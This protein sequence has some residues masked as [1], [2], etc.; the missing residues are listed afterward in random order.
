MTAR[1]DELLLRRRPADAATLGVVYV[2]VLA[3]VPAG[4]VFSGLPM[5]IT[6]ATVIGLGLAVCWL[7][8]QMTSTL[9]MAKGSN[10]VR[11]AVF[12][13]AASLVASYAFA[14]LTY[15]PKDEIKL[16][17]QRVVLTVALVG[18]T[19]VICDGIRSRERLDLLMQLVV[20]ACAA[21]ALVGIFQFVLDLDLTKYL[22]P[23]GL[24]MIS[25][26]AAISQRSDFRRVAGTTAHPI[27]FGVLC[28]MALPLALHYGFRAR[29]RQENSIWWWLCTLLI[30]VGLMFSISRSAVLGLLC[31]G[32]IL[33]C[34]WSNRR[35]LRA[36]AVVVVFLAL[37]RIAFPGLLGTITGLFTNFSS[38]TS[39][40]YRTHDYP[41]AAAQIA[42]SPVFG[43]GFG[44]FYTPKYLVFDNQYL[45]T[46]VEG[47]A[48]GLL[49]LVGL[50]ATAM[51]TAVRAIVRA[52]DP[53]HRDLSVALLACVSVPTVGCI[54]FDLFS[55]KTV[56]GVLFVILGAIG[57]AFRLT[58]GE[59]GDSDPDY[60][61]PM[62]KKA[63]SAG[64]KP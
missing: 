13:L 24:T 16:A 60:L 3:I 59:V 36:L 35:R 45:G 2:V 39:V 6:P 12:L 32:V 64:G 63:G 48:V 29:E 20:L 7:C 58:R 61:P 54:T 28:A 50:F 40:A 5:K 14:M 55:F 43:R 46:F 41:V 56:S 31:V 51:V 26:D 18:V 25:E 21:V 19:L 42:Q 27:E 49:A 37:T 53:S 8:A 47:G 15:L 57:C 62:R 11:T 10:P 4:L 22:S 30:T 9:G 52:V 34:S 44:T 17:D 38:D 33:F 1:V 23:P